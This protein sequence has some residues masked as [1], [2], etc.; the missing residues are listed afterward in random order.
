MLAF[1]LLLVLASTILAAPVP[2]AAPAVIN[3]SHFSKA[4]NVTTSHSIDAASLSP[5]LAAS[6]PGSVLNLHVIGD[7][8]HTSLLGRAVHHEPRKISNS[9][10]NVTVVGRS[11]LPSPPGTEAP[12]IPPPAKSIGDH[13]V[14]IDASGSKNGAGGIHN[15]TI[16]VNLVS[17]SAPS[18]VGH[19]SVLLSTTSS[20][21]ESAIDS[22]TMNINI[23]P[24][25]QSIGDHSILIAPG[26]ESNTAGDHSVI[27]ES[28]AVNGSAP[29]IKDSTINVTVVGGNPKKAKRVVKF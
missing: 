25:A 23:L 18:T 19:H 21:G 12:S 15:S 29:A 8:R 9:T 28:K 7:K 5:A 2:D 27:L 4:T 14:L 11:A 26:S 6:M 16:N 3:V 17:R 13:S 22:S 10:I 24:R 20:N 1:Q